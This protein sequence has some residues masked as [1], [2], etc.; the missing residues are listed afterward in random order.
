MD[1]FEFNRQLADAARAMS[2]ESGTQSTLDRAVQ[3]ATDMIGNCDLAGIS[4]VRPDGIDTPA[5]SEETFRLLDEMQYEM[6]EGP[7]LE[8]LQQQEVVTSSDLAVD[9][10][11]PHWG[12]RISRET[13]VHSSMSFRLFTH[14]NSTGALNLYSK[15]TGAFTHEDYL[16]GLILAAHAAVALAATLEID[17]LHEGLRTRQ[18]IGEAVGMV[19]ER[20]DLTSDQ[21]FGVLRHLSSTSNTKLH[22]VAA[23]IVETGEI[24]RRG[25]RPTSG[26]NT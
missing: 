16:D 6:G 19:R 26:Q 18:M 5:A 1:R 20:F 10:R 23:Q 8:A 25:R 14:E 15:R 9:S 12:P 3:M 11:W 21:A 4:L 7:C 24:P 22:V 13:G 17:Q 2:E